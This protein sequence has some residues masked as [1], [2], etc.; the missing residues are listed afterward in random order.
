MVKRFSV[1]LL[2]AL[3]AVPALAPAQDQPPAPR[4][5]ALQARPAPPP[6]EFQP[7]PW[8]GWGPRWQGFGP[9][10]GRGFGP[11]FDRRFGPRFGP[12]RGFGPGFEA[13]PESRPGF[14]FGRGRGGFGPGGGPGSFLFQDRIRRELGLTDEQANRLRQM[15]TGARKNSI[16]TQAEL[17]IKQLELQELLSAAQPDRA[18]ID[19]AVREIADLRAAQMKA[20]IDQRLGFQSVLTPEQREKLRGLRQR[21]FG[22]GSEGWRERGGQPEPRAPGRPRRPGAP[23]QR[24]PSPPPAQ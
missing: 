17:Q 11:P 14:G 10:W 8:R 3:F 21:G 18:A 9:E 7:G 13:D 20:A 5:R 24:P 16:R 4:D 1:V 12:P 2:C 6:P 22:P 23:S 19:R 15:V